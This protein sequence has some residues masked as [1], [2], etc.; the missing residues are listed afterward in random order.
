MNKPTIPPYG[1][2]DALHRVR[3]KI[4]D[5]QDCFDESTEQY[6]Q[7]EKLLKIIDAACAPKAKAPRGLIAL[8]FMGNPADN[9]FIEYA[10]E[11]HPEK[12][13][14]RFVNSVEE[15]EFVEVFQRGEPHAYWSNPNSNPES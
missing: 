14:G 13:I 7:N 8:V 3:M 4:I 12:W 1:F 9:F 2:G 6:Q 15:V 11:D 10:P 5:Y